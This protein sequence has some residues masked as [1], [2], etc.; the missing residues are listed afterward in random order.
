MRIISPLP[1]KKTLHTIYGAVGVA[2][3]KRKW[4][5]TENGSKMGRECGVNDER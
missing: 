3:V 2:Q 4:E 5:F 1:S